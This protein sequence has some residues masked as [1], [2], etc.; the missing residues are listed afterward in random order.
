MNQAA[1]PDVWFS[2]KAVRPLLDSYIAQYGA[3]LYGLCRALT[4]SAFEA[5]DLYQETWLKAL[6]AIHQYDSNRPFGPWITRICV[7]TYRSQLRRLSR[8]PFLAFRSTQALED[9]L[10][11]APTP[12][13]EDYSDLQNAIDQLPEKLR[14]TVILFY[15][16]DLD[17]AAAAQAL[18]VP[19][20]TVKSRLHKARAMLK[21]VLTHGDDLPF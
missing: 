3:R 1:L 18:H 6:Q 9:A 7:N 16:E 13:T 17:V 4:G 8:S 20:G 19:P 14:L 12:G 21:E 15:F 5:D 11:S 10:Q 2:R